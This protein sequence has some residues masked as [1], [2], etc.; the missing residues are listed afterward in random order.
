MVQ[1]VAE[2]AVA[3]VGVV[4]G[5]D[6]RCPRASTKGAW[7]RVSESAR[8]PAGPWPSRAGPM[9]QPRVAARTART[10][11]VWVSEVEPVEQVGEAAVPPEA[12]V[13]QELVEEVPAE[14]PLVAALGRHHFARRYSA[15]RWALAPRDTRMAVEGEVEVELA[16]VVAELVAPQYLVSPSLAAF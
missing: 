2:A 14:S 1:P 8:S 10:K 6:R 12:A 11:A 7:V 9:A 16:A 4:M 15:E 13:Q 5:G 3:H